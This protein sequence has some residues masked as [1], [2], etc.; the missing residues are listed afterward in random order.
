[1][2]KRKKDDPRF[3]KIA[4]MDTDMTGND[5]RVSYKTSASIRLNNDIIE[6]H[7]N[8][9]PSQKYSE[10]KLHTEHIQTNI[11]IPAVKI[12]LPENSPHHLDRLSEKELTRLFLDIK[13]KNFEGAG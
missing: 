9:L 2:I 5:T 11:T 8:H 4:A 10:S 13:V 7:K 6:F 3:Q 12:N 1:M